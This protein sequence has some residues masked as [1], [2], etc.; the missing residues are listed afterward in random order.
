MVFPFMR[1]FLHELLERGY[2]NRT[3]GI[4]ENGTWAPT[5]AKT[6]KKLLEESKNISFTEMTVTLRSALSEA[7]KAEI[8]ALAKELCK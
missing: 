8:E 3:V 2:Q 1:E 7:N 5:A 4:I 6:I